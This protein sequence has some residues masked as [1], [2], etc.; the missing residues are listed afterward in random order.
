M[1]VLIG[2][3]FAVLQVALKLYSWVV[4]IAII[5]S[6]LYAF[7]V[8]NS[9]NKFVSMIGNFVFGLTEPVLGRI[10]RVVPAVGGIDLSAIVLLLGIF[11]LQNILA[12]LQFK[13]LGG[14]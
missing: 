9:Y 14:F 8:V 13:L 6:W 3:L 2:P 1:D 12:Q 7:N 4:I 11:F 5:L 10:R